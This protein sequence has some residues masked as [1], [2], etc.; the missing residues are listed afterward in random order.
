MNT[1]HRKV[2]IACQRWLNEIP[3]AVERLS[4]TVSK[5]TERSVWFG[6]SGTVDGTVSND[7]S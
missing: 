1:R 2:P 3:A 6:G 5:R 4:K 7:Y